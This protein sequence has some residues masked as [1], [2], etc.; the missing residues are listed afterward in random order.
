MESLEG[1]LAYCSNGDTHKYRKDL[2]RRFNKHFSHGDKLLVHNKKNYVNYIKR[3]QKSKLLFS[4]QKTLLH[5]TNGMSIKEIAVKENIK[6]ATVWG[7]LANLIE[8]KQL[9]IW[10]VLPQD[11]A[12]RIFNR[13]FSYKERLRDIKK[14]LKD[15]SITYDEIACVMASIKSKRKWKKYKSNSHFTL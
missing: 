8:H 10:Q 2:V 1:W 7:H 13:I 14:R 5:Y 15:D 12:R 9:T 3:V 6:E 4:V 11:K